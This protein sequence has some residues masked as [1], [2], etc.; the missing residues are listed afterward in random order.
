MIR[1]VRKRTKELS[2]TVDSNLVQSHFRLLDCYFSEYIPTEAKTPSADEITKL[3]THMTPLF[4]FTLVWSVGATCDNKGRKLFDQVLWQEVNKAG[5]KIGGEPELPN[6][7]FWY[8]Y[9]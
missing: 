1:L 9:V 8:D 5:Q 4:F 7:S 2:I 3:L 6:E